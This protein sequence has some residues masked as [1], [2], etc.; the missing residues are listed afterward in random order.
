VSVDV[1]GMARYGGVW[2]GMVRLGEAR[3]GFF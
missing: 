1:C 2:Q 3:Y